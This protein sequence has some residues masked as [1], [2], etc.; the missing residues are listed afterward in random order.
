MLLILILVLILICLTS[1]ETFQEFIYKSGGSTKPQS[2]QNNQN[3]QKNQS[4]S[5]WHPAWVGKS[6]NDCYSLN[7]KNCL[8][9]S[10]CGLCLGKG[11]AQCVPGDV[12]G[13]LF[14]GGCN[15]WVYTN[16]YDGY[17]FGNKTTTVT[18]DWNWFYP[19]YEARLPGPVT[20]STLL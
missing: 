10:N 18:R 11:K 1:N 14:K 19:D 2:G 8:K 13:P 7:K 15:K 12:Q 4:T 5:H 6:N 17:T 20:R 9:Y 16:Y 3:N